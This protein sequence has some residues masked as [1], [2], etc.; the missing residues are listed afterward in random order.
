MTDPPEHLADP[1]R[2]RLLDHPAELTDRPPAEFAPH[3]R[4]LIYI[5]AIL[6]LVLSVGVFWAVLTWYWALP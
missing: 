3:I 5:A 1:T 2:E 4:V 6:G